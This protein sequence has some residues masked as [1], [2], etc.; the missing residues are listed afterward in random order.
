MSDQPSTEAGRILLREHSSG[1]PHMARH[2]I[3]IENEAAMKA[4]AGRLA[5]QVRALSDAATDGP[6][7]LVGGATTWLVSGREKVGGM[8]IP[9]VARFPDD[10]KP[11]AAFIVAA[12]NLVR[13]LIEGTPVEEERQ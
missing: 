1:T 9:I 10:A 13:R 12:V 5:K 2:I 6:W 3:G 11:D 7:L 4:V 8:P